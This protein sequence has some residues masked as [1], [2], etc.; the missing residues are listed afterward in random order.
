[1]KYVVNVWCVTLTLCDFMSRS[2]GYKNIYNLCSR[3]LRIFPFYVEPI[4]RIKAFSTSLPLIWLSVHLLPKQSLVHQSVSNAS[5]CSNSLF[6]TFLALSF[7]FN[8]QH[9]K[10]VF[11]LPLWGCFASPFYISPI[12][13]EWDRGLWRELEEQWWYRAMG[14]GL[15]RGW[16]TLSSRGKRE[17]VLQHCISK[18]FLS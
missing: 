12:N 16:C 8:R 4:L 18:C 14:R 5:V 1:M 3:K 9:F 13:Y 17:D 15:S 11:K 2:R 6:Y 7:S 10:S